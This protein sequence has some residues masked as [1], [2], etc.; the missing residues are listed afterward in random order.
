MKIIPH[1]SNKNHPAKLKSS[2]TKAMSSTS[3]SK[4]IEDTPDEPILESLFS[5][6]DH[7]LSNISVLADE[8]DKIGQELAEK[9]LPE[10][11]NRYKKHIRLLL[12]GAIRN[13]EI[14][15]TTA[16][17]G[18]TR[19]KLFRT[20]QAIDEALAQLAQRILNDEKNRM[21]IL[22]ITNQL[23]GLILDIIT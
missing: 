17:S 14:R 10:I 12:K 1:G 15:E 20:A 2:K 11:F 16:R 21:E 7:V 5:N 13:I 8:L 4:M 22:K 19:T 6:P 3:F 9:P 23:Q 18:L